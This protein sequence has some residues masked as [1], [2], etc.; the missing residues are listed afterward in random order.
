MTH[1]PRRGLVAMSILCFSL[2]LAGCGRGDI[3][4]EV[5]AA[6]SP[7]PYP[8]FSAP[9]IV[10]GE[11]TFAGPED[12]DRTSA[13]STAEIAALMLHSW[14]TQTDRTQTAAAIRTIPLMSPEWAGHQ[15]E[16]ERNGAQ[17]AWLEPSTHRAYSSP[18]IV[19]VPEDVSR[20]VASDKAV[21]FYHVSWRWMGRDGVELA[22]TEE[23][24]VTIYLEQH[25]GRWDVVGHQFQELTK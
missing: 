16:P 15:V 19:T 2:V 10:A 5:A 8:S 11:G 20:D 25:D 23:Q 1:P 21:R 13:D 24:A 22:N 14:D 6:E 3:A 12:A 18:S 4:G 9:E 7:S 17:G